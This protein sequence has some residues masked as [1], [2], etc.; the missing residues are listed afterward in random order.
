M[1]DLENTARSVFR[2]FLKIAEHVQKDRLDSY[3]SKW[4]KVVDEKGPFVSVEEREKAFKSILS[5]GDFHVCYSFI[6]SSFLLIF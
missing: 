1:I 4:K 6:Y 5:P 2:E 3:F